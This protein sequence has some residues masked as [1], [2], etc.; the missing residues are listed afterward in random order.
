MY[1]FLK[2]CLIS[3][4][5]VTLGKFKQYVPVDQEV[6]VQKEK[7][8]QYQYPKYM[9]SSLILRRLFPYI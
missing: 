9:V 7:Q 2:R 3:E 1:W 8:S 6:Q 5:L 4:Q